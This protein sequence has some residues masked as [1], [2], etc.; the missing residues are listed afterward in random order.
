MCVRACVRACVR[1]CVGGGG[2]RVCNLGLPVYL[3]QRHSCIRVIQ[4]L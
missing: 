1:G 4:N 2:V 3:A